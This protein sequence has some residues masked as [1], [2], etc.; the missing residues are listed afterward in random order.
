M[1]GA[2][3]AEAMGVVGAQSIDTVCRS[4]L[5]ETIV[6]K[7][8]GILMESVDCA[9]RINCDIN[10]F[11]GARSKMGPLARMIGSNN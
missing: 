5:Q 10:L 1:E 6:E 8:I 7:R 4:P 3:D 9:Y 2:G 11:G